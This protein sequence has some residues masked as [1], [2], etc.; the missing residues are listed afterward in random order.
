MTT[1]SA[2]FKVK[3]WYQWKGRSIPMDSLVRDKIKYQTGQ[4]W[5]VCPNCQVYQYNWMTDSRDK[6]PLLEGSCKI[7]IKALWGSSPNPVVPH[8]YA[9][10]ITEDGCTVDIELY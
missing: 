7:I 9:E 5:Q 1:Y 4:I 2:T 8:P 3:K 10:V 6:H